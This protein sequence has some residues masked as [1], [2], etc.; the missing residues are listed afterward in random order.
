[1]P[2]RLGTTELLIIMGIVLLLFGAGRIT[3]VAGELGRG[4]REF[5][6]GLTEDD[7]TDED[8]EG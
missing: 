6:S 1:M 2:F 3:R 4:I 7:Q 5:R 8:I